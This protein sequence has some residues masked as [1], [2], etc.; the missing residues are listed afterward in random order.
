MLSMTLPPPRHIAFI[1]DGN[2]R[3]A[4][5]HGIPTIQ[6]HAKG[7]EAMKDIVR[8]CKKIGVEYVTFWAF[9]TENW[10][11]PKIWLDQYFKL[12]DHYLEKQSAI[13]FDNEVRVKAIGDLKQ[14]PASTQNLL[15]KLESETAHFMGMQV[16]IALAYGG[17]NELT[18]AMQAIGEKIKS[19]ILSPHEISE[20]TIE[21]HL[22]TFGMPDIDILVRT[23]G[24][25]R[26][27]NYL[28]YQLAYTELYFTPTLWPDLG[29]DE[30]MTILN[31]FSKRERRYGNYTDDISK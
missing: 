22:D 19:G 16:N 23:G 15:K 8:L 21:A 3:Y 20:E 11:R 1:M 29:E 12:A 26:L 27:S 2:G 18:R 9:S 28:L 30:I 5:K 4:K 17:R 6:G 14:L 13:F 24:D 31:D 10:K 25:H 7:A